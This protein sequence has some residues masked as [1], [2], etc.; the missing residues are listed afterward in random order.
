MLRVTFDK[1]GRFS[2]RT[3]LMAWGAACAY[4]N[5]PNLKPHVRSCPSFR[6]AAQ[7]A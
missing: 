4:C 5:A 3:T 1:D 2:F 7:A 6:R